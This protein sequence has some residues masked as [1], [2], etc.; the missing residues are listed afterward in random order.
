MAAHAN[1]LFA[2]NARSSGHR[3]TQDAPQLK[4]QLVPMPSLSNNR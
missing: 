2:Y 3:C 4:H 1:D